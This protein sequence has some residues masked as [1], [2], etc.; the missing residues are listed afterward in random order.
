MRAREELLSC[1]AFS[2]HNVSHFWH[3]QWHVYVLTSVA[4]L[5]FI[6]TNNS[7]INQY[8]VYSLLMAKLFISVQ[9]V[10]FFGIYSRDSFAPSPTY[11]GLRRVLA[12]LAKK[13]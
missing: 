13:S 11:G 10:A 6:S 5:I 8:Q 1:G 7:M 12:S 9:E 4:I 2:I 3:I